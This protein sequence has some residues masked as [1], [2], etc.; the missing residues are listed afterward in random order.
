[1]Y[2][3]VIMK[4]QVFPQVEGWHRRFDRP[5]IYSGLAVLAFWV[6]HFV[7]TGTIA[8]SWWG[9]PRFLDAPMVIVWIFLLVTTGRFV[10]YVH[11]QPNLDELLPALSNWVKKG[12]AYLLSFSSVFAGVGI[13]YFGDDMLTASLRS[14]VLL[15]LNLVFYWVWALL[16]YLERLLL[17]PHPV[18]KYKNY[19][20]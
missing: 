8:T 11:V 1:M 6:W 10:Q 19:L 15:A 5:T 18:K 2:F 13:V 16:F 4:I 14:L 3:E 20:T 7:Y 9:L 17:R 12:V